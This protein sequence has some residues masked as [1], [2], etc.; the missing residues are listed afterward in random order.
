MLL[1]YYL[2]AVALLAINSIIFSCEA[3]RLAYQKRHS[4]CCWT[5]PGWHVSTKIAG[6]VLTPPPRSFEKFFYPPKALDLP[7]KLLILN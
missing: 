4:D 7:S 5:C 6:E 2:C 1:A 3:N